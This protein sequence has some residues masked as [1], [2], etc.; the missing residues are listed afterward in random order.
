MPKKS[1]QRKSQVNRSTKTQVVHSALIV[2]SAHKPLYITVICIL[3]F[4]ITAFSYS[5]IRANEFVTMDDYGYVLDNPHVH[6]GLTVQSIAWAFSTFDQGNWHPLTWISHMVDWSL[7]RSNPAG[8]HIA[9]VALHAANAVLLFLLLLYMTGYSGRSALVAFLFALH[10]AHV[11]SVAWLSE[12]KDVLCSIFFLASL[13]AYAWYV[14]K[15]S[16]KRFAW[17]ICGFA[18]A[19]LSK[20]MAVTLPFTLL[21]LDYWPLRRITFAH[22][23][24]ARWLSNF[25]KLCA[26][27]WLLFIMAAISSIITLLAQK[28]SG[29]VGSLQVFPLWA[30]ICNAAI[31]YWRYVRI[32]VWPDPLRAYYYHESHNVS[33]AA[34]AL[35]II[36]LFLVTAVCW[37]YRKV[38]PYCLTGW[39]WFLGTLAPVIG[40]V[41]VGVQALAERYAYLP[42]IG[43]FIAI[44]WLVS[45]AVANS[46][47][48]KIATQVLAVAVIIAYA[49]KTYAQ[50]QVWKDSATLFSHILEV[51][52]RGGFP[53]YS[54]GVVYAN[55]GRTAEAQNYFERALIY[56]PAGPQSLSY[57]AYYM[58]Q[59]MMLTHDRRNL[60]LAGK[61]LEEA[62]RASPNSPDILTAMAQWFYWMG[63]PQEEEA[64]S[65]RAIAA[66]PDFMSAWLYLADGLRGQ[67][68]LDEAI[69]AY[70]QALAIDPNAIDAMNNL[71]I[72]YS[73]KGMTGEALKE[74]QLSLA[75]KPD[76]AMPH[77]RIGRILAETHRLPEAAAEFTRALQIDPA[78]PHA[79]NDLGVALIQMGDY[80]MAAEQFSDAVRLDPAY[81]NARQNLDFA[82]AQIKSKSAVRAKK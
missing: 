15:P 17:V 68:K 11:E 25:S 70:R 44:V 75:I 31:S 42:F 55:Q 16:W 65:R 27:K 4:V 82:L 47:K 61:R 12:R 78:N 73:T 81:A 5:G 63:R 21:L 39:L 60:P 3:L 77:S 24:R 30:R 8:H 71:G 19:L 37:R 1:R 56:D 48:L 67:N 18:C 7:Y 50:V 41:Q 58:M 23:S 2:P 28:S 69:Q 79:H 33:I 43:L 74:F 57:S 80:E 62:L 52:P 59:D 26:E 35:S 40:I 76:Q 22:E 46:P 45:D 34:A 29:A 14:R 49:A 38:K 20:P 36:A 13:L 10:P 72:I 53:N 32:M 51:D 9:N 64:Y 66:R 54:L 6:Q